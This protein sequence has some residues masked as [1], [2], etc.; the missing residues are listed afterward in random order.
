MDKE[1]LQDNGRVRALIGG[2]TAVILAGG[3]A[4]RMNGRMKSGL[5]WQGRPFWA[6]IR[7]ELAEFPACRLS[8]DRKD[9]FDCDLPMIED[10][11]PG[12]GPLGAMYSCLAQADTPLVFFAAC[13]MPLLTR[14][15]VRRLYSRWRDTDDACI[16]KTGDGRRHPLCGIYSRELVASMKESLDGGERRVMGFLAGKALREVEIPPEM[17]RQLLNVNTPQA[18]QT[19][20]GAGRG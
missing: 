10:V 3:R 9:R 6:V 13:D 4:T 11:F 15:L 12:C 14:Q 7:E 2:S 1:P 16:A 17:E 18:Y 19:L 20:C 5:L 8:V